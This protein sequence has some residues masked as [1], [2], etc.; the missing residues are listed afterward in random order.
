MLLHLHKRQETAVSRPRR[1]VC[2]AVLAGLVGLA[3]DEFAGSDRRWK[4]PGCASD[5]GLR[6]AV[7]EAEVLVATQAAWQR[8]AAQQ[9]DLVD[10]TGSQALALALEFVIQVPDVIGGDDEQGVHV[11]RRGRF[12]SAWYAIGP[13]Y[14]REAADIPDSR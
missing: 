7:L 4:A 8:V 5:L 2:T 9:H 1:Q 14:L 10:T 6:N 12:F 11:A 13:E 3:E